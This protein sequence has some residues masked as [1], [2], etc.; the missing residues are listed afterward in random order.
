M[1]RVHNY[2]LQ[3]AYQ[4][5]S[6]LD[7]SP[8]GKSSGQFPTRTTPHKDV[9]LYTSLED[10]F[11]PGWLPSTW[12]NSIPLPCQS[13]QLFLTRWIL[14][15][16]AFPIDPSP[17][18]L[19]TSLQRVKDNSPSGQL[20]TRTT[21]YDQENSP[22]GNFPTKTIFHLENSLPVPVNIPGYTRALI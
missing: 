2:E 4:D 10:N 6:S 5:N 11:P 14:L 15:Q 16:H 17:S 12:D 18:I 22:R 8:P 7:N 9:R 21:P 3:V 19:G 1:D 13:W 20:S